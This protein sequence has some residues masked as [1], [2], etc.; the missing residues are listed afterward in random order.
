MRKHISLVLAVVLSIATFGGL[1]VAA[2]GFRSDLPVVKKNSLPAP[3]RQMI[4]T[5][6]QPGT[7]G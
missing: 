7:R 6:S 1:A 4:A 5:A 3:V 2:N